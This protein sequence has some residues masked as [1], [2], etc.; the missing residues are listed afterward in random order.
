METIIT[1][2]EH[3][4]GQEHICCAIA[5]KKC[6]DGYEAKKEWLR[7][8]I[9]NGFKFKKLDVRGKVF[10]EYVPAEF[11]WVP[12]Y[13]PGTMMINFFWVSGQHKGKGNGKRLLNE[14]FIDSQGMNGIV[15]ISSTRKQSVL[16]DP[17][18]FRKQGFESCD[19]A[20]PYFELW[21]LSMNSNAPAPRFKACAKHGTCDNR[22]GITVYYS[23]GCPFTDYYVTELEEWEIRYPAHFERETFRQIHTLNNLECW[24]VLNP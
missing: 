14:C 13:T 2:T 22:E 5:D 7:N 20:E 19:T 24:L 21:F 16:S 23:N 9:A 8:Q 4:I 3:N 11:A 15:A 18:F 12:V 1:L 10:I 6:K 17:K